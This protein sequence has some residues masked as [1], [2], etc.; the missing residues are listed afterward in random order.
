ML[1]KQQAGK[2]PQCKTDI[3][4]SFATGKPLKVNRVHVKLLQFKRYVERFREKRMQE[5]MQDMMDA[6]NI[7]VQLLNDHSK[8]YIEAMDMAIM[9]SN[10]WRRCIARVKQ[11]VKRV[12]LECQQKEQID[13]THCSA[14]KFKKQKVAR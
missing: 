8:Q 12:L 3:E 5:R 2:K 10:M 7:A 4:R 11:K 14:R 6:R 13:K 1:R 9:N